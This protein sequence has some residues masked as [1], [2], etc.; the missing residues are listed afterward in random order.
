MPIRR[1]GSVASRKM[2][3]RGLVH[4]TRQ[5]GR[6][7]PGAE[8]WLLGSQSTPGRRCLAWTHWPPCYAGQPGEAWV[9]PARGVRAQEEAGARTHG[10]VISRFQSLI[11]KTSAKSRVS[12]PRAETS[13]FTAHYKEG[14]PGA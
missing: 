12:A 6:F 11:C 3:W 1:R 4:S 14:G 13:P 2:S 10:G 9:H 8:N 5:A 7:G